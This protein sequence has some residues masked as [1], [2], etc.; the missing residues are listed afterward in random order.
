MAAVSKQSKSRALRAVLAT[1]GAA[2]AGVGVL[3][4]SAGSLWAEA[5]LQLFASNEVTSRFELVVPFLPISLIAVGALLIVESR[6]WRRVSPG[7]RR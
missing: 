4:I 2:A 5:A 1:V 6:S 3:G 7:A